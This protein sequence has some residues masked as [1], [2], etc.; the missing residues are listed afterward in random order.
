MT[1]SHQFTSLISSQL[2]EQQSEQFKAPISSTANMEYAEFC[3]FVGPCKCW[4][5]N[6]LDAFVE[7]ISSDSVKS[8]V[9]FAF[10]RSVP[11]DVLCHVLK[12]LPSGSASEDYVQY[13]AGLYE[14]WAASGKDEEHM[15]IPPIHVDKES[16]SST[17][18]CPSYCCCPCP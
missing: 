4:P 16:G 8:I 9:K 2:S 18:Y 15:E 17:C 10:D 1:G 6:I 7:A 3:K 12:N 11:C 5:N 13:A 14:L